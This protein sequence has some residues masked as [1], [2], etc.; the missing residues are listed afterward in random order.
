VAYNTRY[1]SFRFNNKFKQIKP[2]QEKIMTQP[3]SQ[4]VTARLVKVKKT[5]RFDK[6][7]VLK[8]LA[9]KHKLGFLHPKKNGPVIET[10]RSK[11]RKQRTKIFF[12]NKLSN[13]KGAVQKLKLQKL[14]AKKAIRAFALSPAKRLAAMRKY[15]QKKPL[16]RVEG[17]YI[18]ALLQAI[19]PQTSLFKLYRMNPPKMRAIIK[20]L[21]S[22][23][24]QTTLLVKVLK[25]A[26]TAKHF[27]IFL[28]KQQNVFTRSV[29][30]SLK[31][32]RYW[33]VKTRQQFVAWRRVI[34]QRTW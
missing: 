9:V 27:N 28:P 20:Q 5:G 30:R 25:L 34:R 23:Y 4:T 14:V 11:I 26:V 3:L 29:K 15:H 32:A 2:I 12:F 13:K 33:S 22:K 10:A 31:K 6:K 18:W 8:Q 24:R 16:T 17:V 1:N 21:Q 19:N 7:A